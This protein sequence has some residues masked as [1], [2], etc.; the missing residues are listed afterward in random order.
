MKKDPKTKEWLPT[1]KYGGYHNA[2]ASCFMLVRFDLKGKREVMVVP[3]ELMHQ[4]RVL[5]SKVYS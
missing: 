2:A 3:V 4:K 5:E 1:E